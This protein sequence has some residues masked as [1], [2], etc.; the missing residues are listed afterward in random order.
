MIK[1][2]LILLKYTKKAAMFMKNTS[3]LEQFKTK[4]KDYYNK[5]ECTYDKKASIIY[6]HII[7]R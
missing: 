6:A 1:S 7:N 3:L 5:I 4:K 2:I